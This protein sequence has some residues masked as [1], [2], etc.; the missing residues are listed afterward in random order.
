MKKLT[1]LAFTA[2]I[3]FSSLIG[4]AKPAP[5]DFLIDSKNYFEIGVPYNSNV[6]FQAPWYRISTHDYDADKTLSTMTFT[7]G[8]DVE[9]FGINTDQLLGAEV[10]I[11]QSNL[12]DMINKD[13]Y[14]TMYREACYRQGVTPDFNSAGEVR[15]KDANRVRRALRE[16]VSTA[17]VLSFNMVFDG[18]ITK[19]VQIDSLRIASIGYSVSFDSFHITPLAIPADRTDTIYSEYVSGGWGGTLIGPSMSQSGYCFVEGTAKTDIRDIR[20]ESVNDSCIVVNK[21]NYSNYTAYSDSFSEY[22]INGQRTGP[23]SKNEDI[24]L[25]YDYL[26]LAKS[27]EEFKQYDSAVACLRYI[28]SLEDGTELNSYVYQTSIRAPEYGLVHLLL[29]ES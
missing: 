27:L 14:K 1:V 19:D 18:A 29:N 20:V 5:T 6:W 2:L 21:N 4:C 24:Y 11:T 13:Y 25:E 16:Y 9:V 28:V 3:I 8:E 17:K 23:F 15:S 7:L 26:Y 12:A 10:Y 22:T